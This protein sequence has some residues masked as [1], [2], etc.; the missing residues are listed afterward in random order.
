MDSGVFNITPKRTDGRFCVLQITDTHL[1]EEENG[2][3]LGINTAQSFKAVLD[4]IASQN[5]AYD[6]VTVT[7]DISQDYSAQSYCRFANMAQSLSAP[8]FFLPGNH[9]DGPLEYRIF[10]PMGINTARHVICGNW[11]FVFLNSEVYAQA[12]GWVQRSELE[13]LDSCVREN[14]NLY[15]VAL[16]HHLP[17]MVGSTWLDTQTLHNQDEFIAFVRHMETVKLVLSGHVHQEFD[18]I[19][20]GIRYI[21]TPSTSIQFMPRST[22]FE[23]DTKGP[24]WRYLYFSQDGS[25]DTEVFRLIDKEKRFVPNFS[26]RGY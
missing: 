9:D 26:A 6:F 10:G 24:G 17:A 14:P 11:Q 13:F 4:A 23:L 3:L 21:A 19:R 15:T 12:H 5:I 20:R 25:F 7:G 22:E 2:C 18:E 8:I 1:F 16:I